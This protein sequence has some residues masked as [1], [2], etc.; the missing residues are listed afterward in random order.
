V[1]FILSRMR[2][3]LRITATFMYPVEIVEIIMIGLSESD[4]REAI[5]RASR[6]FERKNGAAPM[7][8]LSVSADEYYRLRRD[9]TLGGYLI[10][11]CQHLAHW[12]NVE[13]VTVVSPQRDRQQVEQT[14]SR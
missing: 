2:A 7:V 5:V 13:T 14:L 11:N 9:P 12:L 4:P 10:D 8:T 6:E 3:E 1:R